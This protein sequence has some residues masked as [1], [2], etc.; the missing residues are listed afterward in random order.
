MRI[1]QKDQDPLISYSRYAK[2]HVNLSIVNFY[3]YHPPRT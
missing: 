3:K 2:I 1:G